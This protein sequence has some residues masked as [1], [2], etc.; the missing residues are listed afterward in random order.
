MNTPDVP[1]ERLHPLEGFTAVVADKVFPLG[2]D[3][4]VSV[5]SACCD[6]SLP[7]YF[8]LV[9]PLPRVCP[10]VS[11]EVGAVTKALLT[12]RAAVGFLFAL[13]AIVVVVVL[14]V[15]LVVVVEG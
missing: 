15:V 12:N 5:Q 14:V 1:A 3:R 2:V 13:L 8:T 6:K 4:L 7:A 11:C 10:D 9:R